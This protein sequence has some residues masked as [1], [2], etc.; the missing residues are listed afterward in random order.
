MVTVI[1]VIT[2]MTTHLT[3]VDEYEQGR[4]MSSDV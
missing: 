3:K 2:N 4:V 1:M